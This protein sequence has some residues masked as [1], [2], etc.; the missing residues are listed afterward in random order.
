MNLNKIKIM[1]N[2]Q[3]VINIEGHALENVEEY[4]YLGHAVRLGKQNQ[5]AEIS[6]RTRLS[7]AAFG[8]LGYIFK[9]Q[10]IPINLK[11]K[12]YEACILA[13]TT[14][15]HIRNDEIQRRTKVTDVMRRV[16][17][18]KWRWAGH[19]ARQDLPRWTNKIMQ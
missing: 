3:T 1:I 6:R 13:V 4:I 19:V 15:D 2:E 7:W 11:R 8:R 16:A 9:S 10:R 14:Y 5:T 18:L 12:V 17:K